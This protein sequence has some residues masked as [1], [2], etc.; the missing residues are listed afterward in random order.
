MFINVFELALVLTAL[1]IASVSC[2]YVSDQYNYK[3]RDVGLEESD[4]NY[5]VKTTDDDEDPL[6]DRWERHEI[7]YQF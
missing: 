5:D 6:N 4:L 7:G 2:H 3:D 1:L